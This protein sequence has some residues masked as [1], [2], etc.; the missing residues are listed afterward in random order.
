MAWQHR[1]RRQREEREKLAAEQRRI[2][3]G[4]KDEED[5]HGLCSN[6]LQYFVGLDF[7]MGD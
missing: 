3:G 5:S 2:F 1:E 7:I 4:E 6:M